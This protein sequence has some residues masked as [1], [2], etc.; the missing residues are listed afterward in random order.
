[1]ETHLNLMELELEGKKK[2][3]NIKT[4]ENNFCNEYFTKQ[5]LVPVSSACYR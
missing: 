2:T 1:M 3:G 4:T 5:R